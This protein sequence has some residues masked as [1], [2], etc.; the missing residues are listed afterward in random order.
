MQG[1]EFM[2]D[3][4]QEP[5]LYVVC[6]QKRQAPDAVAALM[7]Y[8]ILDGSIC[9]TPTIHAVL[10]ARLVSLIA[11]YAS[12]NIAMAASMCTVFQMF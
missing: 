4:C 1:T 11:M 7:Y 6:K 3:T 10:S 8:Y 2:L 5:H 12:A 9:Q